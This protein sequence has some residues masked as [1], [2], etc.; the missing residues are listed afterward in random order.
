MNINLVW[1]VLECQ[2]AECLVCIQYIASRAALL[3]IY[4]CC[5]VLALML[6]IS[7]ACVMSLNTQRY[8]A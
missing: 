1:K 3:S 4:H 5:A 6:G 7:A 2:T 8:F